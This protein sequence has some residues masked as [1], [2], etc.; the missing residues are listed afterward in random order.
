MTALFI[1]RSQM[2]SPG[3]QVGMGED[4]VEKDKYD[5]PNFRI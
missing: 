5:I 2:E 3:V 4:S 1:T